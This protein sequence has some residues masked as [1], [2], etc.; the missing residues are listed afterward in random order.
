MKKEIRVVFALVCTLVILTGAQAA[1]DA[2]YKVR[3]DLA[4]SIGLQAYIYAYPTMDLWRTFYEGTLDPKRG[5]KIRLNQFNHSRKLVTPKVDWV[6]TPNN[7]TIYSRAFLDIAIEPVVLS[8]P[9]TGG[10]IYWCPVGDIYH[11]HSMNANI[12]WDTVGFKGGDFALVAP[13][14]KGVLPEGVKR[15]DMRTPMVWMVFRYAV[16]GPDDVPAANALQNKT[17]LRPLSVFMGKKALPQPKAAT[18]PKFTRNDLTDAPKFF[19]AFNEILRRN[20]PL[21]ADKTL[22]ALFREIGLDP[23]QYFDWKALPEETRRGLERAVADA[24][25]IVKDRTKSFAR[26]V[27][28]WVELIV[29]ADM[30]DQ[31]VNHAGL[32]MMGLLYSQKE[33]STYHVANFDND[34]APLTGEHSY[35]LTLAPPPPVK[36]FWS[37]T[38]Y[39]SN[40]RR[41]IENPIDRWA[42][43]DRT[44]GLVKGDDGSV[45]I[46][47][48][49]EE[50]KD[51]QAQTNW[52]PAPKGAF[53][54]LLREYSPEHAILTRE[55]EPPGVK[56]DK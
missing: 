36:A 41:Y 5:H 6:V 53:Y 51:Q 11:N 40:T 43:S 3:E 47:I 46:T 25:A 50:P 20:P 42:I 13:G 33:V 52:L 37:L 39:D 8:V 26:R 10:R 14:W 54:M 29:D 23:A 19:T 9:D 32:C 1:D 7:D 17:L 18:Y 22:I 31:P 21:P 49:A 15:I 28:G 38:L 24:H 48:S 30:S 12:S 2:K 27:N 35:T 16:S 44:E 56:K 34:G 45:T 4:Y 55:W